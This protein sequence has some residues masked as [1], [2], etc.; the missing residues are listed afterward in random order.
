MDITQ[1]Q[2]DL[3]QSFLKKKEFELKKADQARL[4]GQEKNKQGDL[5]RWFEKL[6]FA[7][8]TP[9]PATVKPYVEAVLQ[10]QDL[11]SVVEEV[12]LPTTPPPP[13][14][15]VTPPPIISSPLKAVTPRNEQFKPYQPETPPAGGY[16]TPSI[17]MPIDNSLRNEQLELAPETFITRSQYIQMVQFLDDQKE[18]SLRRADLKKF[19]VYEEQLTLLEQWWKQDKGREDK[20]N[21][22]LRTLLRERLNLPVEPLPPV[23]N[24]NN[25]TSS[26]TTNSSVSVTSPP[27]SDS[28][29]SGLVIGTARYK[30]NTTAG[31]TLLAELKGLLGFARMR[32]GSLIAVEQCGP[33]WEYLLKAHLNLTLLLESQS[34]L[35]LEEWS[36]KLI[37]ISTE[38]EQTELALRE[39]EIWLARFQ[40]ELEV[41]RIEVAG[42]ILEQAIYRYSQAQSSN[43]SVGGSWP[44][45][46]TAAKWHLET[47]SQA[48]S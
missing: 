21:D 41:G 34:S 25:V 24:T 8:E 29:V 42:K 14:V 7:P 15:M 45:S 39:L 44:P 27:V 13:P 3:I 47:R 18:E 36:E 19:K 9:V 33:I 37:Q 46:L 32:L 20:I 1:A 6:K 11:A 17:S 48:I 22:Q 12:L 10:G 2:I 35:T 5:G 28:S 43:P 26:L 23:T 4:A 40:K 38:L 31:R 30:D 16:K